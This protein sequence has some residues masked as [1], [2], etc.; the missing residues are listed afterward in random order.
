MQKNHYNM[1]GRS[2]CYPWQSIPSVC[3]CV[4]SI[5]VCVCVPMCT[6]VCM[7]VNVS[8][9]KDSFSAEVRGKT[10][11]SMNKIPTKSEFPQPNTPSVFGNQG[12]HLRGTEAAVLS[13]ERVK[14]RLLVS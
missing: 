8:C 11:D 3:V 12:N 6:F 10:F 9:W 4:Y 13:L 2:V 7:F 14:A 5:C 1:T